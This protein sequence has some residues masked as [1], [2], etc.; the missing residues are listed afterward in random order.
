M[1]PSMPVTFI[2]AQLYLADSVEISVRRAGAL[3]AAS[4]RSHLA[5]DTLAVRLAVPPVGPA[6]DLHLQVGAPSL[7]GAQKKEAAP[8]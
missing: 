7:P 3:P 6:E 4:F 8:D 1:W 5:M 2:S